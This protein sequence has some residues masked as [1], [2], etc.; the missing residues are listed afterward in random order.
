MMKLDKKDA[1]ELVTPVADGE[2]T[3]EELKAFF[4][5]I[6]GN[7]DVKNYYEEELWIKQLLKDKVSFEPAPDHLKQNIAHLIQSQ[8]RLDRKPVENLHP[9]SDR[10]GIRLYYG[11]SFR[12]WF[13]LAAILVIAA[14]IYIYQYPGSDTEDIRSTQTILPAVEEH[15][16]NH[17]VTN[18]GEFIYP[19]VT[20]DASDEIHRK[21]F[22]EFGYD[23]TVPLLADISLAG[24]VYSEFLPEYRSPLFEYKVDDGDFIYIFAFHIPEMEKYL[25]R[26]ADA[27]DYC[28]SDNAYHITSFGGKDLVSWKW[29]DIWYVGIS[30]HDGQTFTSLLPE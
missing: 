5:Y 16:Y 30:N 10:A 23:V 13:T 14:F 27:V 21:V 28:V 4:Q 19:D 20:S 29:E 1:F 6:N 24:V 26:N 11:I 15:V 2:A 25:H 3:E 9:V 7:P 17:F 18:R 8:F 12:I 22:E